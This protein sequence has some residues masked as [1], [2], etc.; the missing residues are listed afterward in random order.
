MGELSIVVRNK[1]MENDRR[2][3]IILSPPYLTQSQLGIFLAQFEGR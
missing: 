1:F 2:I 3:L